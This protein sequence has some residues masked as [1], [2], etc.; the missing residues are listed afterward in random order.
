MNFAIA[1]C[2]VNGLKVINDTLGHKAG[3]EY[4]ISACRM[5]CDI[6]Q[7]SPVYR[8]GGDEFVVILQG[9]DLEA[10]IELIE[11]MNEKAKEEYID[12]GENLVPIS[13]ACGVAIYGEH[14]E[15]EFHDV[16]NRADA[17]MYENKKAMKLE[18]II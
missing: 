10:H 17:K 5:I 1:V 11:Q 2:D 7:H 9:H 15:E 4:I 13:I 18:P 14:G 8:T 12:L 3:D 16:L 6:F